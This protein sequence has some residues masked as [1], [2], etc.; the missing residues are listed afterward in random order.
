[1]GVVTNVGYAHTEFFDSIEGVALAK[2][3]LIDAL[4]PDGTAVLNADDPRMA[5]W[6]PLAP[7]SLTFGFSES[8]NL[9]AE[10]LQLAPDHSLFDVDGVHFDIPLQGR[11]GVMNALA[12]IAVA[13][14]Y[15]IPP[16]RLVDAARTLEM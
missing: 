15:G 16:E 9:R 3:E 4:P 13:G 7:H 1:V 6:A 5:S 10:N 11:H 2:R 12:A 14:V 8:A